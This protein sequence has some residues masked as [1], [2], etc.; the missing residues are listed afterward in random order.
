MTSAQALHYA[1][2]IKEKGRHAYTEQAARHSNGYVVRVDG[3]GLLTGVEEAE[4]FVK[5]IKEGS[6]A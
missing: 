5:E 1:A 2:A 6:N 4:R 3:A